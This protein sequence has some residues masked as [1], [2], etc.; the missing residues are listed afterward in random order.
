MNEDHGWIDIESAKGNLLDAKKE[1]N[2]TIMGCSAANKLINDALE[3]LG[4]KEGK[5]PDSYEDGW[6]MLHHHNY[7]KKV[8]A[9]FIDNGVT[10]DTLVDEDGND[11]KIWAISYGVFDPECRFCYIL[12]FLK[13]TQ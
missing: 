11:W 13:E 1:L 7:T 8:H 10:F 6:Y 3:S 2:G 9:T 5:E 12:P 4:Y